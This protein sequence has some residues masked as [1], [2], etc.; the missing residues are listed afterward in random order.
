MSL[1]NNLVTIRLPGRYLSGLNN[2]KI[3]YEI[4]PVSD[5][6]AVL[7]LL[8]LNPADFIFLEGKDGKEG[9]PDLWAAKYRLQASPL[10]KI[11]GESAGLQ[12]SDT[13]KEKNGRGYMGNINQEQALRLNLLLGGRTINAKIATELFE[14]LLSRKA[15]DGN[16]KKIK[17]SEQDFILDEIVGVRGPVRAEWYEDS[18]KS[19]NGELILMKNYILQNGVLVPSYVNPLQPCLMQSKAPGISFKNW[20]ENAN[21]QGWPRE[22]IENGGFHYWPPTNE[23]VA[24]FRADSDWAVLYGSAYR[25]GAGALLGARHL[26]EAPKK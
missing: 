1:K 13:A 4:V 15:Y 18:F 22:N 16:G 6:P 20:V 17:D 24:G 21:N 19:K 7:T 12:L 5:D 8:D 10:V 9:H 3:R 11:I 23:T 2:F 14:V 25:Q 26:R